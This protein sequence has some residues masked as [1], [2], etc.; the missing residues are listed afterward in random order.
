MSIQKE[1]DLQLATKRLKNEVIIINKNKNENYQIVQDKNNKF[2]FYFQFS[3][4]NGTDHEGGHYLGQL[5]CP[6]NYP[7]SEPIFYMFTPNG[8]LRTEDKI[9]LTYPNGWT[10]LYNIN[11]LVQSFITMFHEIDL[12]G[13]SHINES[14]A[15]IK[16][17]AL[18]S[19]K[20][21][22]DNHQDILFRFNELNK[23]E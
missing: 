22:K 1:Q 23:F 19:V 9:C 15:K 17:K 5:V 10:A 2:I 12:N 4:L 7:E 18:E 11:K 14:S 20:Y 8:R 21:N 3:G 16:S 13:I 6:Q